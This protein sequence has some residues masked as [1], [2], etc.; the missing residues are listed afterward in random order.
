MNKTGPSSRPQQAAHQTTH[1]LTRE[2]TEALTEIISE[3]NG[4]TLMDSLGL[5]LQTESVQ[6]KPELHRWINAFQ[7]LLQN[8]QIDKADIATLLK[9]P[10]ADGLFCFFRNFPLPY[11][12]EHTHLTG[13][14]SADFIF[15]RLKKLLEGPNK[16]VYE[17]KIEAIYGDGSLPIR[18]VDDVAR[19]L[20]LKPD[21]RFSRYLSI[22]MLAKFLLTDRQAHRDAAYHMAEELYRKYNVGFIRLKFTLSRASASEAEQVPGLDKLS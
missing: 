8:F 12:D 2:L 13:A 19:L 14:L 10:V 22:L 9:H 6:S 11:R 20:K 21:E 18:E 16:T 4:I 3:T 7:T 5:M 1:Q 17:S 15:P